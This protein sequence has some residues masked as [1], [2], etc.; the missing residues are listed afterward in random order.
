MVLSPSMRTQVKQWYDEENQHLS[1]LLQSR[2]DGRNIDGQEGFDKSIKCAK[3]TRAIYVYVLNGDKEKAQYKLS[4]YVEFSQ[5]LLEHIIE[6]RENCACGIIDTDSDKPIGKDESKML[7]DM[8]QDGQ[9]KDIC[10]LLMEKKTN[11]EKIIS[12]M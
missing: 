10:D 5:E 3:I 7:M 11:F 12:D 1:E 8:K 6:N 2:I 4:K 9:Y